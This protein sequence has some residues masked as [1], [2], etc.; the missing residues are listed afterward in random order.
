MANT[1]LSGD[2]D[3]IVL[4]GEATAPAPAAIELSTFQSATDIVPVRRTLAIPQFVE[5]F[6]KPLQLPQKGGPT[7]SPAIYPEG[8]KRSKSGV[9]AV[10]A[11]VMDVDDG[12]PI[13]HFHQRLEG[14]AYFWHT[15]YSHTQEHPKYRIV[16]FLAAPVPAEQWGDLWLRAQ[17][18]MGGH[19]D[20]ATKDASRIYFVP[21][22]PPGA[23][24]HGRGFVEGVL[25]DMTTL[26][27][28]LQVPVTRGAALVGTHKV[29]TVNVATASGSGR[30]NDTDVTDDGQPGLSEVLKRCHAI[31]YIADPGNQAVISEPLWRAMLSN[32]GRFAGGRAF[33]HAA[34]QRH[35][36]YD[37][38]EVDGRLERHVAQSG[39]ITCAEIQRHGYTGCPHGGCVLP[40]GQPTRAPAGLA[41]WPAQFKASAIPHPIVLRS[42]LDTHF[43]DGLVFANSEFHRYRAGA[44]EALD[45]V[46]EVDKKLVEF[47]G[48]AATSQ[49]VKQL[50]D[51]LVIQQAQATDE[52]A[53]DLNHL[54]LLNGT[55]NLKSF[56]LEPHSPK[57][58]LRTRLNIEWQPE[59]LAP[60]WLAYLE[61]VFRDDPDK[62]EKIAFLQEWM[63]YLLVPDTGMQKMLWLV[64]SGANG[65]SVFL[66][67]VAA[68]VGRQNISNAMLDSFHL[69]YVR[70][71]LDGKLVNIAGE[72]AADA[73]INDGFIK[74][75][76]AGDAIEAARKFKPSFSFRPFVRLMAATNNLPR[77]NDLSH[78]F[79]R[80]TIILQFNRQFS[81]SEQ[82]PNLTQEL[83]E[84]LPGILNWAVEGLRRLRR[85][86]RFT[87]PPSSEEALATYR[88]EA[89]PVQLFAEECLVPAP[90]GR[91]MRTR[92][93]YPLYAQWCR[94][95]GYQPRNDSTFG[96]ALK[97][98][99]FEQK[100]VN[101]HNYW[102]V[103]VTSDAAEYA[104]LNA[105]LSYDTGMSP[106]NDSTKATTTAGV[107]SLAANYIV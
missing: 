69:P 9:A 15:S 66:S 58:R 48:D 5:L 11:L 6:S 95:Y 91:G 13:E 30:A 75:I 8:V 3:D 52:F 50:G 100:K 42:F 10:T 28:L 16:V 101:G 53:P 103:A 94:R 31:R 99:G 59:A 76:V 78:G 98:L 104:A 19:L 96:K 24:G 14:Y 64:G 105:D 12:T 38:D 107:S 106:A 88:A 32:V 87:I 29:K 20:P 2:S 47:L 93:V 57:H 82:N 102:K 97:A 46:A 4:D 62:A 21:S 55:L 7:W 27:P 34:S 49:F 35:P 45:K 26:P 39:P 36:R 18:W 85:Q 70:A 44:F 80:R 22:M 40:N 81:A 51:L 74:A 86:Q 61:S 89:N 63:G 56:E 83:M 17:A 43:K 84:E 71:E 41:V 65:K 33:A 68:L 25:L 72:M 90:N 23:Q 1:P 92:D 54:C 60:K 79:F 73:M 37:E 77:T 67:I